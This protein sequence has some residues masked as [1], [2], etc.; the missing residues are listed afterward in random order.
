MK[1]FIIGWEHG[2]SGMLQKLGIRF[3]CYKCCRAC[4]LIHRHYRGYKLLDECYRL[5]L[6]NCNDM[7]AD[8]FGDEMMKSQATNISVLV[9]VVNTYI[10]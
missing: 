5:G 3:G 2:L 7:K 9:Q 10:N 1:R 6:M 4:F 8:L